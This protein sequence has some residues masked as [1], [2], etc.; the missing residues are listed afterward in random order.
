MDIT[1][2]LL[3][4]LTCLD[5]ALHSTESIVE[6]VL[7]KA[8]FWERHS[9]LQINERQR[10]MLNKLFDGFHGNLT[11]S[12][13]GKIAKCSPDTA[14]NDINELIR[15]KVLKRGEGGGR[16]TNYVLNF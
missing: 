7:K 1:D 6:R 11:S 12:K 5:G 14:V 9:T 10:L 16:S 2:W 13:W 8:R 4:F 3:W 15:M